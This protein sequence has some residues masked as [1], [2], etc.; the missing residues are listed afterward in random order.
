MNMDH[1]T[2]ESVDSLRV[3]F[4]VLRASIA[5]LKDCLLSFAPGLSAILSSRIFA[6]TAGLFDLIGLSGISIFNS[7]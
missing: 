6:K 2:F 7:M 3:L 4:G 1:H 5:L